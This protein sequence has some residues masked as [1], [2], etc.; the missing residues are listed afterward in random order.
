VLIVVLASLRARWTG[1]LGSFTA[2]ALG[3]GLLAAMC[4]GLA[5]TADAPVRALERFAGA[6]VV[7]MGT[8]TLTVEVE[9]G[10]TTARISQR[11]AHPQPVDIELL[12]D[13]RALGPLTADGRTDAV[14]VT[15]DPEAVR[16]V[17][18]DRAQV[19]TGD[20]RRRADP[21]PERDAE[22]LMTVNSLLGTAGG[23]TAFV[24][25]F[26]VAST[27]A[28]AVALRRR[29]FGLLR[30]AGATPRQLRVLVLTEA[31]AVG[32][33]ASAAGCALGAW[34]APLLA[35]LL[36]DG[37]IAPAWFTVGDHIWPFHAAFWTGL[38]VACAGAWTASRRAGRTG[39]AEALREA[40]AESGGT[41]LVRRLLGGALLLAGAGLLVW[42][43]A[44]DPADLLK[45]KTYTT[46]PMV[47]ITA[48]AVLSP[49][50]VGPA[51]RLLRLPGAAGLLIRANVRAARR[52]TAAVA[53][54]VLVTVAMAGSLM[55]AAA[56]VT[57]A[58][59]A[60]ARGQTSADLVVTG[61]ELT[62]PGPIPGALVSASATT[63]VFVRE[64]R[65]AL[66]RS[67]ARAV[68][69]PAALASIARLPVV[70]GDLR[71]LD[72]RSIVVNEEWAEHRVGAAVDVW[73]GDGRPVT[74]RIAAVLAAGTGGNGAYVT[75]AN[76]P[77]AQLDRLDVRLAGGADRSAV[78][79][80][81]RATGGDVRTADAW[82]AATHPR[83]G[84]QVRLGLLVVLGIALVYTAIALANTL[85]MAGSARA[86]ELRALRLTGATRT[87]IA[88]VAAGESL[89]AVGIGVLL[90]AAV[91]AVNLACLLAALAALSAPVTPDLPWTVLGASAAAC[92]LIAA[93]AGIAPVLTGR[94]VVR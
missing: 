15:A 60:E 28:F 34:G 21:G 44:T 61:A 30:T 72:D 85:V 49:V 59:G 3:V 86:G 67:E 23:V 46:V 92:A 31:A 19:L 51:A 57:A 82:A 74:L 75:A 36:V 79:A 93:T 4:L 16:A 40:D 77:A 84:P 73:L 41:P 27:F 13:L 55:G 17:V 37:G 90:G 53:A 7:V 11:L 70:A 83:T 78:T 14:G 29:E 63:A 48:V 91:T 18:G 56:T 22:A 68:T 10:P 24:A 26:V 54:P 50:L 35:R 8:D 89:L 69:D 6:P 39:P 2:L 5:A 20:E 32:V 71:D 42:T 66:V 62:D 88:A 87:Q 80:A 43:L 12:R 76:V 65:T 45:R 64:D 1:L 47:L 52:R 58:K 81:L 33:V 38:V 9:R 94:R 25:V